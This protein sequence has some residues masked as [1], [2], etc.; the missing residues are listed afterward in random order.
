MYN[1]L[2]LPSTDFCPNRF[3]LEKQTL[4]QLKDWLKIKKQPI[5]CLQS[6]TEH[7]ILTFHNYRLEKS[8]LK[9]KMKNSYHDVK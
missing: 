9:N 6:E 3:K 7:L 4:S 1:K 5:S 2:I 8:Y